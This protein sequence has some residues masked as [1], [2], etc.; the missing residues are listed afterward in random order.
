MKGFST[1]RSSWKIPR[2]IAYNRIQQNDKFNIKDR[3][4]IITP[5]Y[6]NQRVG[7]YNGRKFMQKTIKKQMIGM[8]FGEFAITK[9]M[10]RIHKDNTS[11][12]PAPQSKVAKKT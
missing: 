8:K 7:I 10:G 6:V 12:T 9:K 3:G 5:E 2:V 1:N 4:L 11:R